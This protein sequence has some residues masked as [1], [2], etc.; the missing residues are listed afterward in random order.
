VDWKTAASL[1]KNRRIRF[2]GAPIH[3]SFQPDLTAWRGQ[4]FSKQ[5]KGQPVLAGSFL[6]QREIVLACELLRKPRQLRRIMIHEVFHFVW[7]RLGN[8]TRLEWEAVLRE[9]FAE[10]IDGE[11]GW[12]SEWRKAEL[13]PRDVKART[14][15]WREYTCESFCDTAAWLFT[16]GPR[17]SELTLREPGRRHR[18]EWFEQLLHRRLSRLPI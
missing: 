13:R 7:R 18:R 1:G 2:T 8:A 16:P 12:S 3:V 17:H 15:R 10:G 6:R 4:L 9:E 5:P 14:K 11:A